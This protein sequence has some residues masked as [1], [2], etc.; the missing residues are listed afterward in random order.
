MNKYIAFLRGINISGNNKI[1]MAELKA[2]FEAGGFTEV[3]TYLN[4]GNVVFSSETV[5]SACCSQQVHSNPLRKTKIMQ[6]VSGAADHSCF[7]SQG[8]HLK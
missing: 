8:D 2:E 1:S 7:W 4:S 3:S 5:T 6:K